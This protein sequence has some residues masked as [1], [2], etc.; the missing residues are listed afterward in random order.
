MPNSNFHA[1]ALLYNGKLLNI[2]FLKYYNTNF[3][4]AHKFFLLIISYRIIAECNNPNQR[5]FF[6]ITFRAFTPTPGGMEFQP[7]KDYYFI[8][9]SSPTDLHNR[10]G[11]RC[12]SHS[13]KAIFKI[14][15]NSVRHEFEK[16]NVFHVKKKNKVKIKNKK[17]ARKRKLSRIKLR[18][19][20]YQSANYSSIQLNDI[21]NLKSNSYLQDS[22]YQDT[23]YINNNYSER[24]E[25]E[26]LKP[27]EIS[28]EASRLKHSS[29]SSS[30]Q[31]FVPL[32][33]HLNLANSILY[34]VLYIL[35]MVVII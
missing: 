24:S 23:P 33:K 3:L 9:T 22:S 28:V 5:M 12:K 32:S 20:M 7:G 1:E 4:L 35:T 19:N 17:R 31:N 14:V 6:T 8:S 26:V 15:D 25:N 2:S 34:S 21:K 18:K 27:E 13:M 29:S 11:G 30:F 16:V 10:Y